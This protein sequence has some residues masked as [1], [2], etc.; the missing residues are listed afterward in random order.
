M[1]KPGFASD[2]IMDFQGGAGLG[3]VLDLSAMGLANTQA[4]LQQLLSQAQMVG[5]DT[6]FN[7][8]PGQSIT[9]KWVDKN[10]LNADDFRLG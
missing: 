9:L 6:V 5:G 8:G 7:L 2:V 1:F 10:T 3:D 4:Q